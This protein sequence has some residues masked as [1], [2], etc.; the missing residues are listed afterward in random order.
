MRNV[1][2]ATRRRQRTPLAEHGTTPYEWENRDNDPLPLPHPCPDE[3]NLN[4][5]PRLLP[6]FSA[7][8]RGRGERGIHTYISWIVRG[9]PDLEQDCRGLGSQSGRAGRLSL[10]GTAEHSRARL[11]GLRKFN[12]ATFYKQQ[13]FL[14]HVRH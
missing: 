7:M 5:Y 3:T 6:S 12:L 11:R 1:P 13:E 9:C 8:G 14:V 4:M 2:F 10:H